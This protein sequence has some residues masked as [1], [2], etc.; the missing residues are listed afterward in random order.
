[1]TLSVTIKEITRTFFFGYLLILLLILVLFASSKS[2]TAVFVLSIIF[3]VIGVTFL[4]FSI[5]SNLRDS[6]R[7]IRTL[8]YTLTLLILFSVIQV[9]S[10]G[11]TDAGS[12][13]G[14][15]TSLINSQSV[16]SNPTPAT[17]ANPP[18]DEGH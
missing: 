12:S 13:S 15:D 5:I 17:N 1:M 9:F 14:Q 11:N 18:F 10:V 3:E 16:G 6:K 8:F 4:V 7:R 2:L